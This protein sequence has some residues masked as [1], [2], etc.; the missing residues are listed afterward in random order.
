[1]RLGNA[2]IFSGLA[3]G[4]VFSATT[5]QACAVSHPLSPEVLE[6]RA[7]AEGEAWREAPLV[8]L[9]RISAME[10]NYESYT[11]EPVRVLKGS[12]APGAITVLPE[13]SPGMCLIYHGLSVQNGAWLGD[14]FVVYSWDEQ[15]TGDSRLLIVS[16]RMLGDPATRA[17]LEE[18]Q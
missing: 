12:S 2:L 1:M 8:Y 9:A 15:T 13:P 3:L 10:P 5:G 18:Q 14:A 6:A 16:L 4:L 11:L 7:Q 17:A